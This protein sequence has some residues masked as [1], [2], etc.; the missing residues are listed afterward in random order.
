MTRLPGPLRRAL[1]GYLRA[2]PL[3]PWRAAS[4]L[5]AAYVAMFL[6]QL[7]VAALVAVAVASLAQGEIRPNAFLGW[8]L[9]ALAVLQVP[10]ALAVSS[11]LGAVSSRQAALSRT[12]LSSVTLAGSGWFAALA[13]ATGQR[14]WSVYLLVALVGGA[15]ALGF[16]TVGR[17]AQAAAANP[18]ERSAASPAP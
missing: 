14:G 9:V 16:V 4:F 5:R 17:L 7:A 18:P 15:Y 3:P 1:R 8:V 10:L 2:D 6:A 12:I 13:V 11:R